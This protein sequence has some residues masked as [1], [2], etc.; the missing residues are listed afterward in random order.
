MVAHAS[1]RWVHPFEAPRPFALCT[2]CRVTVPHHSHHPAALRW[3][4]QPLQIKLLVAGAERAGR[5]MFRPVLD[6]LL[7]GLN[8]FLRPSGALGGDNYPLLGRHV[9]AQLR[10]YASVIPSSSWFLGEGRG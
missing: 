6:A 7:V 3:Y 4:A 10:H 5:H 9:L 1:D 8:K 2:Q